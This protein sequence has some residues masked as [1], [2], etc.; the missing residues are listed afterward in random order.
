M[1]CN[2]D[3][4]QRFVGHNL[5]Q[6]LFSLRMPF[7]LLLVLIFRHLVHNV[8]KLESLSMLRVPLGRLQKNHAHWVVYPA[9]AFA[10]I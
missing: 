6:D 7:S 3:S 9:S 4:L 8:G 5:F 10:R 1:V 2:L